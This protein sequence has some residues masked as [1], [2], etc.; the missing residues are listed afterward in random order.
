MTEES[1]EFVRAMLQD[2][3]DTYK[4]YKLLQAAGTVHSL[5]VKQAMV[6]QGID[7]HLFAL[8]VT[9]KSKGIDSEFLGNVLSIPFK[10]STSQVSL[11]CFLY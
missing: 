9:G 5:S 4:T 10:V 3:I 2:R 1:C 6:G 7:R 8:Y 11:Q